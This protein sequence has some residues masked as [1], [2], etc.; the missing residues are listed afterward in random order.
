MMKWLLA[1]A[2]G[3]TESAASAKRSFEE[4]MMSRKKR[5]VG[6]VQMKVGSYGQQ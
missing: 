1:V 3:S 6:S 4:N 2:A 5:D